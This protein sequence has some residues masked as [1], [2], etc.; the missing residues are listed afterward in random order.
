MTVLK[1]AAST[2]IYG[3]AGA[4]GV[5][6]VTTKSSRSGKVKVSAALRAGVSMLHNGN[7]RMMTGSGTTPASSAH[8]TSRP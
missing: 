5:V 3:S 4:N 1:D 6:V 8:R 7:Q 2:A